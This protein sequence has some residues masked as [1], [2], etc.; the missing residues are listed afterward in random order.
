[1]YFTLHPSS[2]PKQVNMLAF[3]TQSSRSW[4]NDRTIWKTW[5]VYQWIW[6]CDS[7][8]KIL[9]EC[10]Y[11]DENNI[12]LLRIFRFLITW[13]SNLFMTP[14][15]LEIFHKPSLIK[16]V[17]LLI[18]TSTEFSVTLTPRALVTV[19]WMK[20]ERSA[21]LD[22]LLSFSCWAHCPAVHPEWLKGHCKFQQPSQDFLPSTFLQAF[23]LFVQLN[24]RH[25]AEP[26]A[27]YDRWAAPWKSN[28]TTNRCPSSR[29][30]SGRCLWNSRFK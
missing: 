19:S 14:A 2:R 23:P 12:F 27:C 26:S 6:T 5:W 21:A 1:M 17:I 30:C 7:P 10:E 18:G 4:T 9:V 25:P 13:M 8:S 16:L 3:S 24:R 11:F 20:L 15:F 22:L 28:F 29:L